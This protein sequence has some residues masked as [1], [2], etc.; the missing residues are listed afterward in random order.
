MDQEA[1]KQQAEEPIE[2]C[3]IQLTE[4]QAGTILNEMRDGALWPFIVNL[5]AKASM[6]GESSILDNPA[7]QQDHVEDLFRV[8]GERRIIGVLEDLPDLIT[9]ALNPE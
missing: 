1:R 7:I 6:Q 2:V 8:Q 3:G 9:I 4:R 5:L